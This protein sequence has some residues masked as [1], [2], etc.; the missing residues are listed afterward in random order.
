MEL[1]VNALVARYRVA[2]IAKPIK[3]FVNIILKYEENSLQ[4]N[5]IL[6]S[7]AIKSPSL[8]NSGEYPNDSVSKAHF[9][10]NSTAVTS[11]G[12]STV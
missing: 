6:L 5:Y 3:T 7:L 1:K 4:S 11:S 8:I 10:I 12:S 9:S 2:A